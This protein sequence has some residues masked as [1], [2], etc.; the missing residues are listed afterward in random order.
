MPEIFPSSAPPDGSDRGHPAEH[1]PLL[2][3][4]VDVHA[5]LGHYGTVW[6]V[7]HQ[8]LG[9]RPEPRPHLPRGGPAGPDGQPTSPPRIR[10]GDGKVVVSAT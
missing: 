9:V 8:L 6:P 7:V 10:L 2:D 3:L 5:G 4:P 1:R